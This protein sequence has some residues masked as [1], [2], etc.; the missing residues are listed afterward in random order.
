M[1]DSYLPLMVANGVTLVRDMGGDLFRVRDYQRRIR[2]GALV[3]PRI[4]TSGP[5]L[6]DRQWILAVRPLFR[7]PLYHRI[8]VETPTEAEEVLDMLAPLGV[9]F[10][11]TRNVASA[12]TYREIVRQAARHGLN[13]AGHEPT[14][15]GVKTAIE[16]GQKSVEHVPL[17]SL[18]LPGRDLTEEKLTELIEA[19]LSHRT[20]FT[21]TLVASRARYYD[22]DGLRNKLALGDPRQD[23]L[24]ATHWKDWQDQIEERVDEGS[25]LDWPEMTGRTLKY[26]QKMHQAGVPFLTGTDLGVLFVYP[27]FSVHD[28]LEMLVE[29]LEMTPRE[30]M[31][32]ATV[33]PARF[34]ES[35]NTQGRIAEGFRADLV[36]L[37]AD[38]FADIANTRE[39]AGVVLRGEFLD[40]Q[41]LEDLRKQ[42]LSEKNLEPDY[43]STLAVLKQRFEE[44]PDMQVALVLGGYFFAKGDYPRALAYYEAVDD[45]PGE[46]PENLDRFLLNL[47]INIQYEEEP[48]LECSDLHDASDQVLDELEKD[49]ETAIGLLDRLEQATRHRECAESRRHFLERMALLDPSTVSPAARSVYHRNMAEYML[50]VKK[51]SAQALEH[52]MTMLTRGW[53]E[54]ADELNDL[55]RWCFDKS[56][57]LKVARGYAEQAV[58]KAGT[59]LDRAK[60]LDTQAE[61]VNALG[62]PAEAVTLIERARAGFPNPYLDRQLERFKKLAAGD[63]NP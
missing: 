61:I 46:A 48:A 5:I 34:L 18:T 57:N 60:F 10:I 21:P 56:V 49:A 58:Q 44:R 30:A 47:K 8:P 9:D 24:T 23:Y 40:R 16:L 52:R 32:T 43:P 12:E 39:I 4:L 17:L 27:G 28:E 38:P 33:N 36:L 13:V 31:M 22:V 54:K 2:E 37:D 25:T 53:K 15:L 62:D 51:D 59:D 7:E 14:R 35:E 6:E 1:N 45:L 42:A 50:V 11:K 55:A 3:G 26:F 63:E 20:Y 41:R 29:Q 19:A